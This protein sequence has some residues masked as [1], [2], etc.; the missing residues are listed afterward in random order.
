M[1]YRLLAILAL[2]ILLLGILIGVAIGYKLWHRPTQPS[3]ESFR[4]ASVQK[5]GSVVVARIPVAAPPK[6]PHIIPKGAKEERRVS[7]LVMPE[8]TVTATGEV[9]TCD[10]VAVNL[11]MIHGKD[12]SGIVASAEGGTIDDRASIDMPILDVIPASSRNRLDAIVSSKDRYA[13]ALM[14]E[15]RP[16]DIPVSAG[17]AVMR[18]DGETVAGVAVSIPL[19]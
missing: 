6:A 4:P 7:L 14:H 3:T 15:F 1:T 9:C 2:I 13:A 17:P 18:F 12:G 5:D 16:F 8:P 19:P 11:S 10:P